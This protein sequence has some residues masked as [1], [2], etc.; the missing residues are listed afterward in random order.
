MR[1]CQILLASAERHKP[2]QI[3]KV[4]RCATQTV[5]NAIPDLEPRGLES[6][7]K[8]LCADQYATYL[9]RRET[10]ATAR[11]AA[12]KSAQFW[13]SVWTLKL[14]AEVCHEQGLTD[15]RLPPPTILDAIVES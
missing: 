9:G 11:D 7:E 12:S 8:A 1:R 6:H 4:L 13:Q 3:A 5:R 10:R 15:A 2:A 14:L